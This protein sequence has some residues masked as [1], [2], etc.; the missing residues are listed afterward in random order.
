[1][2]NKDSIARASIARP[3]VGRCH[4]H[5]KALSFDH[6]FGLRRLT[7]SEI[8]ACRDEAE[9]FFESMEGTFPFGDDVAI[10]PLED[11]VAAAW[12]VRSMEACPDRYELKELVKVMLVSDSCH[13]AVHAAS[14]LVYFATF[15]IKKPAQQGDGETG[16]GGENPLGGSDQGSQPG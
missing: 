14:D 11:A 1:M 7:R 4:L 8:Q 10:F 12:V 3:I 5:D 6:E 13:G 2:I 15:P 16:S 9:K